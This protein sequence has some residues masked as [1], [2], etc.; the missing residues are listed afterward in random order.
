MEAILQNEKAKPVL[1]ILGAGAFGRELE[2]WLALDGHLQAV[3]IRYLDDDKHTGDESSGIVGK[4]ATWDMSPDVEAAYIV[5]ISDPKGREKVV[6]DFIERNG[7]VF[8]RF[9]HQSAIVA[10]SAA[11]G[12]G[13]ILCPFAVVSNN[14]KIGNFVIVNTHAGVGHDCEIGDYSTICS[15]ANIC[16]RVTLGARCFVGT[17]AVILPGVTIGDD[18]VIGAGAVVIRNVESGTTMYSQPARRLFP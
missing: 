11:L 4:I 16:G 12:G 18:C 13:M 8:T 6:N 2:Q 9:K 7:F 10:P 15:H 5:G 17:G 3:D 1:Y 14:A